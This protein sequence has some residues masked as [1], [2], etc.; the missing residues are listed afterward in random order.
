[1]RPREGTDALG[2]TPEELFLAE[3]LS[4][5]M[6]VDAILSESPVS[7]L[8]TLVRL[9][10]LKS[11]LRVRIF[12]RSDSGARATGSLESEMAKKLYER[13]ERDV[14]E[15]PLK[16]P[17]DA[18]RARIADLLGRLGGMNAYELL[19]IEASASAEVVQAK[20]E[21]LARLSHP[22]NEKNYGLEGCHKCSRCSSSGRPSRS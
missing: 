21:E 5:P 11:A 1:M 14:R 8:E 2:W 17:V 19:G 9:V 4:Q 16:L 3:R 13:F 12:G 22:V 15:V 6:T 20:Y 10:Q 18:Y 7:R